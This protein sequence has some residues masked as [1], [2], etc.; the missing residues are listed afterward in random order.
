MSGHFPDFVF[1]AM[2]AFDTF[3]FVQHMDRALDLVEASDCLVILVLRTCTMSIP[4][5]FSLSIP[6]CIVVVLAPYLSVNIFASTFKAMSLFVSFGR[7]FSCWYII[8]KLPP[9]LP[10]LIDV[11]II[12]SRCFPLYMFF[13]RTP[14]PSPI[15]I[16]NQLTYPPMPKRCVMYHSAMIPGKMRR[17]LGIL[18][19]GYKYGANLHG[20]LCY[21]AWSI[22]SIVTVSSIP[23]DVCHTRL[24]FDA[25]FAPP[26][27]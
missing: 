18:L 6:P 21:L 25:A 5:W 3:C 14:H 11:F 13:V 19:L 17:V 20:S 10:V 27:F 26:L 16:S 12:F 4:I 7:I 22:S 15:W 9:F 23:W 24:N 1:S 2:F 8:P